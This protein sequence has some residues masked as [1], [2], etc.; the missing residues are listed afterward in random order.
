MF[1]GLGAQRLLA[2]FVAG[3]LLFNFPLLSLWDAEATLFGVPLFPA[4]LFVVWALLIGVLA[5]VAER[6]D[7]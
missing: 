4:A 6:S 5:W 2:L 7:E 3:W 1:E